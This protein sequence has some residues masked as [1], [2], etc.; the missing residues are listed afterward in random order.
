MS[1]TPRKHCS[2]PKLPDV[3][4]VFHTKLYALANGRWPPLSSTE[5]L[6]FRA[7][8]VVASRFYQLTRDE[9]F[10]L[11]FEAL[12]RCYARKTARSFKY[13]RRA[14]I[15]AHLDYLGRT[16][17]MMRRL[18]SDHAGPDPW[19]GVDARLDLE[20][21]LARMGRQ[22]HTYALAIQLR[23]Q[24]CTYAEIADQLGVAIKCAERITRRAEQ[25]LRQFLGAAYA[26]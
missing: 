21:A 20:D 11:S 25:C 10:A 17:C 8:E 24:G 22:Y 4:K 7:F 6:W 13:V 16:R 15:D 18:P 19:S 12:C 9:S 1:T 14:C 5:R 23:R 26:A 2:W 3:L